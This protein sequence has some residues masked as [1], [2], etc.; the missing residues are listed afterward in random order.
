MRC[1]ESWRRSYL[2][3]AHLYDQHW[4][5]KA[6]TEITR[7]KSVELKL[8][9]SGVDLTCF[10]RFFS[11]FSFIFL[12]N[13]FFFLSL[14][15]RCYM[16]QRKEFAAEIIVSLKNYLDYYTKVIYLLTLLPVY[17]Y[18][19]HLVRVSLALFVLRCIHNY[20]FFSP[21]Y[22]LCL[23]YLESRSIHLLKQVTSVKGN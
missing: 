11:Y 7:N 13:S 15:H 10:S 4:I 5:L 18:F 2:A 17:Y 3:A 16:L 6:K 21:T 20:N 9:I 23:F 14:F 8:V 12:S 1:C 19:D 22:S